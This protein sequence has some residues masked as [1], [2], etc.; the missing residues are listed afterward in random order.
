MYTG[1]R[2]KV[3]A[4]QCIGTAAIVVCPVCGHTA[5][6]EPRERCPICGT[7]GDRF[8]RF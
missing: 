2:E 1:A 8:V 5:V 6:G 7:P 3:Q 4:G